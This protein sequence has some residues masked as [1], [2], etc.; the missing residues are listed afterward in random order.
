EGQERHTLTSL[1]L[2]QTT[3]LRFS[4][5]RHIGCD[6]LRLTTFKRKGA[7]YHGSET[8]SVF[9]TLFERDGGCHARLWTSGDRSTLGNRVRPRRSHREC[10][11]GRNRQSNQTI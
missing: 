4:R 5:A 11:C 10:N 6:V 8:L 1:H 9:L 3:D 7:K 2:F